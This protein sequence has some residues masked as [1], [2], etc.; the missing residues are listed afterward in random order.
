MSRRERE[1]RAY[2]LAVV[3]G[4]AAVVAVVTLVLAVI[5][6]LTL[7]LPILAAIVAGIC[8][9]LFRRTVS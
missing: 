1:S 7:A 3:G 2:T 9:W 5:G 6:V 4:G 8:F